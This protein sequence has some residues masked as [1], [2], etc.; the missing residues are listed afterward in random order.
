MFLTRCV[1]PVAASL[2][3]KDETAESFN[4]YKQSQFA[5]ALRAAIKHDCWSVLRS[6]ARASTYCSDLADATATVSKVEPTPAG[7]VVQFT[8]TLAYMTHLQDS[9]VMIE[10]TSSSF[11][12]TF[13][14]S[15][16]TAGVVLSHQAQLSHPR[17]VRDVKAG[18]SAT[19]IA[20][21]ALP[22]LAAALYFKA[23]SSNEGPWR[24]TGD[25]A[26]AEGDAHPLQPTSSMQ[27]SQHQAYGMQ[28]LDTLPYGMQPH[29]API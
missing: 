7:V 11:S 6:R 26:F 20:G 14:R 23:R 25:A 28:Q 16:R 12:K 5:L 9:M 21:G 3:L 27:Q 4:T 2:T 8:V 22:V 19:A 10:L 29:A 24:A 15:L 18:W 13:T 17:M 1:Q